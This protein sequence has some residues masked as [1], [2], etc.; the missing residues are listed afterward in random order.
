MDLRQGISELERR[1]PE[2]RAGGFTR[3]DGTIAFYTRVRALLGGDDVVLDFGAGRG[4]AAEDEVPF[5][6][7]IRSLRGCRRQVVGV[8][9]D[10]VV[11]GNPLVD[12]AHVMTGDRIPL[13]DQ[14]V[15]LIV[16]T[17]VFEHVE[18]PA[19]MA[20]ELDRVLKP[21]GWLCARTPNRWGYIA[22]GARL[23][24]NRL[25]VPALRRLQPERQAADVFPTHYRLNTRRAIAGHFPAYECCIYGH[26]PE[27]TYVGTSRLG[28]SAVAA[29]SRLG[30]ERL[31]SILMVFLRKPSVRGTS[32]LMPEQAMPPGRVRDQVMAES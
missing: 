19:E 17:S 18:R 14:S 13:D 16:A 27:A 30:P 2:V 5:R 29:L 31:A 21:G 3:V 1:Y 32:D 6:R 22:L 10:P 12:V 26:N 20:A 25:H 7:E 28:C 9:V 23:V 4:L 15:D 8:D 24:P 11:V